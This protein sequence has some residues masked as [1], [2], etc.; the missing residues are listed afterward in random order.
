MYVFKR[1]QKTG[2]V[3]LL[4]N[5][6]FRCEICD[7]CAG[8][9]QKEEEGTGGCCLLLRWARG[10]NGSWDW[11]R[12]RWVQN[13]E[14][15]GPCLSDCDLVQGGMQRRSEKD[16]KKKSSFKDA[17]WREWGAGRQAE[18]ERERE[19]MIITT[20]CERHECVQIY[21]PCNNNNEKPNLELL[22][23][24]SKLRAIRKKELIIA[25]QL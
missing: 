3:L 14:L 16:K 18:S 19:L 8:M 11:R 12:R 23:I 4:W 21:S 22:Y 5:M 13:Q 15:T 17:V 10:P 24:G 1:G 20:L 7:Q 9:Q 25:Q 2:C 6:C